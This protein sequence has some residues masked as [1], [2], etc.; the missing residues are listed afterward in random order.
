[1]SLYLSVDKGLLERNLRKLPPLPAVILY[2]A[3]G[4]TMLKNPIALRGFSLS[5]MFT[6]EDRI[7]ESPPAM[8]IAS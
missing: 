5:G 4:A 3:W 7:E 6:H 2:L 8:D 1:M